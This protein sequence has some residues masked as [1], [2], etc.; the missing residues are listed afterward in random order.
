MKRMVPVV[1]AVWSLSAPVMA[2]EHWMLAEPAAPAAGAAVN[3]SICSGHGFPK[4]E[5]LLAERLLD[6]VALAGPG[7]VAVAMRPESRDGAWRATVTP[8]ST[9]VWRAEFSLKRPQQDEPIH[10][11]RCLVI[12]GGKD[13]AA[14]YADGRGIEI[15]PKSAVS[16]LKPG[17]VLPLEIRIDGAP[18]AGKITV[19]PEKGS[20]AFLSAAKDRPAELKIAAPGWYLLGVSH[21]GRTFTLTFAVAQSGAAP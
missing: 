8:P 2:H 14:V 21:Q 3:V 7:G 10:R 1:A 6:G 18:T 19:M 16:A 11:S 17:D 4:G 5:I 12:A 20:V 13:D 15:V 9:G